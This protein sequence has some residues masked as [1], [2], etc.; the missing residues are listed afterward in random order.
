LSLWVQGYLQVITKIQTGIVKHTVFIIGFL[1]LTACGGGGS[2]SGGN[3]NADVTTECI[4]ERAGSTDSFQEFHNTCDFAVNF[5][6]VT[7]IGDFVSDLG[8]TETLQPGE[9]S[10]KI[11][12]ATVPIACRPPSVPTQQNDRVFCT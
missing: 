3:V 7:R 5:G 12:D 4:Q 9:S 8:K 1:L 10:V 2:S 6:T 11:L